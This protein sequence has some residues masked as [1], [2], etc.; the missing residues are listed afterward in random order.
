[1]VNSKHDI[2]NLLAANYAQLRKFGVSQIGLFGSFLR[3]EQSLESD[4]D[5][6]VEF[7]SGRKTFDAFMDLCFFLEDL[8]QRKVELVTVESLSP[9]IGPKILKEVEYVTLAA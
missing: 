7:E 2:L 4:I 9:H 1:M 5:L 8:F 3:N 6:L